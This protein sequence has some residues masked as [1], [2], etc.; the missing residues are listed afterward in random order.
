MLMTPTNLITVGE[1]FKVGG[2]LLSH[3]G[4]GPQEFECTEL[5]THI[6]V[7]TL[8][9]AKLSCALGHGGPQRILYMS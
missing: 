9:D 8:S 1:S 5:N 2:L 4:T 3:I 7:I 6:E